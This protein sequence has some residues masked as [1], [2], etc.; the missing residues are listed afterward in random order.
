MNEWLPRHLLLY[1]ADVASLFLV[2]L[3]LRHQG[4]RRPAWL[5]PCAA[6][7]ALAFV[8]RT[9]YFFHTTPEW[10]ASFGHVW[11][12]GSYALQGMDPYTVK[13]LPHPNEDTVSFFYPPYTLPF[14]KFFALAPLATGKIVWTGINVVMSLGLGLLARRALI[15]QEGD[16]SGIVGPAMAALLTAPLIL[17][18]SSHLGM[19]ACQFSLLTTWALLGALAAQG[20]QRPRPLLTAA[21]LAVASIKAQTMIP[22]LL[23]F[24]GRRD[25]R[26]WLFLGVLVGGLLLAAGNPAD[27]PQRFTSMLDVN[28]AGRAPG[29]VNDFSLQNWSTN[30]MIGFELLLACLGMNDHRTVALLGLAGSLALGALL[31]YVILVRRTLPRGACC[32]L[33]SLYSMLFLYHRLY[34]LC[35]LIIPLLYS[36][37]RLPNA[38]RPARWCHAWVLAAVLLALNAPYGEF[39]RIRYEYAS[40][41]ILRIVVLP[42]VTYLLLSAIVAVFAAAYFDAGREELSA[43]SAQRKKEPRSAAVPVGL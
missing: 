40:W 17:S 43:A 14:F 4:L 34:D 1:G 24:L 5:W 29:K 12:A 6:L 8:T 18:L 3:A 10:G 36:A 32:S 13:A 7:L 42:S 35:I 11:L 25:L 30:T 33:V 19:E 15:A 22:F 39:L 41:T 9:V 28:A 38:S 16:K 26:T 37:S 2:I 27:L 21:F 23:L 31:A 20:S